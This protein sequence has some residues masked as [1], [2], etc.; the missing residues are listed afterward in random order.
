MN[1][2]TQPY[3]SHPDSP[4]AVLCSCAPAIAQL[5]E[6]ITKLEALVHGEHTPTINEH[7]DR[8]DLAEERLGSHEDVQQQI[9]RELKQ[10]SAA[11]RQLIA[12]NTTQS[13]VI[14]RAEKVMTSLEGF[15]R[16]KVP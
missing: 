5:T 9:L 4:T 15:L 10:N 8:L 3:G 14:E 11:I 6:R 7:D 2:Q 16:G 13:L 1:D 12:S